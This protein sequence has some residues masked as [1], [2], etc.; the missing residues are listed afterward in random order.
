MLNSLIIAIVGIVSLMML[1]IG[2]QRK[3]GD[4]FAEYV[5]DEDVLAGRSILWELRLYDCLLTI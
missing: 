4:T 3:W 1:W 2:I 5:S